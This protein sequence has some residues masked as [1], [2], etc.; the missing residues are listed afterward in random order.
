[1]SS[2]V[3][4]PFR[5]QEKSLKLFFLVVLAVMCTVAEGGLL[6]RFIIVK[7]VAFE[8]DH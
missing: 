4:P 2:N 6:R 3:L 7:L 8:D 5:V 1:M